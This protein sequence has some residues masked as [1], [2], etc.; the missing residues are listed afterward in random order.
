MKIIEGYRD[1]DDI[2]VAMAKAKLERHYRFENFVSKHPL[3]SSKRGT[4]VSYPQK[5]KELDENYE[6]M[7]FD[8]ADNSNESIKTIRDFSVEE[9]VKFNSR[10]Y[11]KLLR[12]SKHGRAE[13]DTD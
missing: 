11:K 2:A 13:Q 4:I 7:I 5:I 9:M 3:Y 10:V 8:L 12:Q 6:D 1:K